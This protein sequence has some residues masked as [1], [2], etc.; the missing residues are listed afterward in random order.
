MQT[1]AI[2][3]AAGSTT[4]AT[5]SG[6][7]GLE[8]EDFFKILVTELQQQDP[9][10]PTKTSD[11]IGQIS[12]IRSIELSKNLTDALTQITC[13][14]RATSVSALIGKYVTATVEGSDGATQAVSGVVTG[15]RFD[16]DGTAVL[17]LDTGQSVPAD[18]VTHITTAENAP[19]AATAEGS[20]DTTTTDTSTATTATA[21]DKTAQTAK[22]SYP[23][24]LPFL[25]LDGEFHL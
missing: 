20:D 23:R 4:T 25:S 9:L 12:Q 24:L 7:S 6:M 21:S 10:Q 19:A 11:W 1:Q 3:G 15:V 18:S 8:S 2:S 13:N 22:S 14:Q 5:K 17:E 16:A